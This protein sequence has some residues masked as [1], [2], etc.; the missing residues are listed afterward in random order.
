M[1]GKELSP[2]D[3][4]RSSEECNLMFKS[5]R[6]QREE[7]KQEHIY[8]TPLQNEREDIEGRFLAQETGTQ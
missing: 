6:S 3:I 7:G 5:S 4:Y 1:L 8:T 2:Q